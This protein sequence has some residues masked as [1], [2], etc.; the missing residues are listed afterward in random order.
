MHLLRRLLLSLSLPLLLPALLAAQPSPGGRNNIL[1]QVSTIDALT[2]GLFQGALT[3]HDLKHQGD[4]GVGTFE[5]LD[6][7]MIAL[8]GKF[9]Q[10]R[11][12]GTVSRA[13]PKSTT[14]FAA[15]TRF[16]SD[17]KLIV[18]QPATMAQLTAQ[19]DQI[20]SR[21]LFYAI[22]IRGRFAS[23]LNRSVTKQSPPYP[24][25]A[26]VIAQQTLFPDQNVK[27][28]MVGFRS[29]AL[30]KGIQPLGYHFHF[31]ADDEKSGGHTLDFQIAE[32]TVE[33]AV[34]GQHSTYMPLTP[35]F[36]S[37]PF[38]LP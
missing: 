7:E 36:L 4:F 25:L 17:V 28:T 23:F 11:S 33:I 38:P 15:V 10:A 13:D 19:L 21:N 3:Y 5:G 9:Y 37:A 12:D 14:P 22:K 20:L 26:T 6:G 27:G 30:A 29:P 24:P 34:I 8:D 16:Q 18:S 2:L 32:G 1:F 35:E 31:I